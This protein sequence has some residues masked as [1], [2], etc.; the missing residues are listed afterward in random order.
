MCF[1]RFGYVE[2]CLGLLPSW[3]SAE[4]LHGRILVSPGTWMRRTAS[5]PPKTCEGSREGPGG[6]STRHPH[7]QSELVRAF[8]CVVGIMSEEICFSRHRLDL[9]TTDE[10]GRQTSLC[11]RER[12]TWRRLISNLLERRFI[13]FCQFTVPL[14]APFCMTFRVKAPKSCLSRRKYYFD[15][16]LSS[17]SV[18]VVDVLNNSVLD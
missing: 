14:N 11:G 1:V 7:D 16:S 18:V 4:D 9:V 8:H 5:V 17:V 3:T 12:E 2:G 6:F 15:G 13:F 10:E